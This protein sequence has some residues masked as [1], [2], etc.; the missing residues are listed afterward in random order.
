MECIIT[1]RFHMLERKIITIE[2]QTLLEWKG[3]TE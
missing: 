2:L 3:D 1:Y